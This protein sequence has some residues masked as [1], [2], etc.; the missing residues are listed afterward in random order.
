MTNVR[1]VY[2]NRWSDHQT[3]RAR[4]PLAL[5][6]GALAGANRYNFVL[7]PHE[8]GTGRDQ[9]FISRLMWNTLP[10]APTG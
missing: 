1:A 9:K 5:S 7:G 3:T 2:R 10:R 6:Y 8:Q 4:P